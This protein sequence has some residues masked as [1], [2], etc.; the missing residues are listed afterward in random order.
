MKYGIIS[1][2]SGCGTIIEISSEEFAEVSKVKSNLKHALFIEEKLNYILENYCEFERELLDSSV[3]NM[4]FSDLD[5]SKLVNEAHAI[6]RRIVNLLS[7]CRLYLDQIVHNIHEIYG[8]DSLQATTIK[9]KKSEEFDLSFGYRA[10]EAIRN[11]VQHR[12]FPVHLV[13]RESKL[14]KTKNKDMVRH[15]IIPSI[16]VAELAS[17]KK[18]KRSVLAELKVIG[19]YV[20]I[21]PL[22]HAYLESIGRIHFNMREFMN[23]DISEWETVLNQ[24]IKRYID[25]GGGD[26]IGLAVVQMEDKGIILAYVAVFDDFMK[27]RQILERRNENLTH[28]SQHYVSSE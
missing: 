3:D 10:L 23:K 26:T 18:F 13:K 8:K 5:W 11:Y 9:A 24:V 7:A 16:K 12:G 25:A 4:L 27:R 6:N 17:D 19:E 2:S 14:V 1:R 20:D 15:T 28:Y 22:I 21:K